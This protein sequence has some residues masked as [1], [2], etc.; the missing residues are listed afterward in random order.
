MLN[1]INQRFAAQIQLAQ[2]N[3][4]NNLD[5]NNLDSY[6]AR[7]IELLDSENA[8]LVAHYYTDPLLQSL[9]EDTGGCV[10]DS[11]EMARFGNQHEASTLVVAGVRFMGETAKILNPEKRVLMPTLQATCSLDLGCPIETFSAFCDAHPDH[12]VVVYANTSAEVKARADWV[13]TSGIALDLVDHLAAEGKKILWAPDKHLGNYIKNKTGADMLMWDSA[14]IVHEE[15]KLKGVLDMKKLYPEAGI[16]V[17]PESPEEI[18]KVA[19]A[20]GST[21]QL[22]AAAKNLP[23]DMFIVATDRGIFYKMQQMA[24]D[25]KFIEAPTAGKGA[26]CV[27]CAHCPWMAM[28]GLEN[29][30]TSLEKG[31]NEVIV[32]PETGRRA[33]VPLQRMLDFAKENQMRVRGNA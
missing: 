15:F 18:V 22:I 14:C 8:V 33:M 11:L 32:D 25:K 4:A 29:L 19:D 27:S 3:K 2:V 7:I 28:N 10:A 5:L 30:L 17:H 13:V 31:S 6:R 1:E 26:A 12:E 16:L 23:N 24:P 20:V 9:A 21:T